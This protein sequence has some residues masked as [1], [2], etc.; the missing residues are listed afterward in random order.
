MGKP[1]MF[2]EAKMPP[3]FPEPGPVGTVVVKHYPGYRLARVSEATRPGGTQDSMFM[4]LFRHIKSNKIAMTAPVEMEYAQPEKAGDSAAEDR[5]GGRKVRSMAF[6]YGDQ[7]L[8]KP[9]LDGQV[10][11]L[12]VEPVTVVSVAVRGDYAPKTYDKAID[13]ILAFLTANKEQY[14]QAG[15]P[16]VLGYNSPFVPGFLR[17]GEVQIPVEELR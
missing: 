10:E 6:L 5:S 12:D 9:G 16:R 8:G 3:G 2:R 11:V 14:R 1:F 15:P 17:M 4:T 13:E 7:S